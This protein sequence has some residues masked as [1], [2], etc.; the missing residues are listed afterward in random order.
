MAHFINQQIKKYLVLRGKEQN[1]IARALGT[2]KATISRKLSSEKLGFH[3]RQLEAIG[4]LLNAPF[5]EMARKAVKMG[6]A[7]PDFSDNTENISEEQATYGNQSR[8]VMALELNISQLQATRQILLQEIG[9]LRK[10]LADK[11]E[12]IS[13][14][15]RAG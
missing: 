15:K 14:L 1:D 5:A 11:D 12:I 3:E 9:D 6:E 13:S 7:Y 8:S 4:Q 10:S 2:T